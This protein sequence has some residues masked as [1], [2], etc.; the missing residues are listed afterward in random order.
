MLGS[1]RRLLDLPSC[2]CQAK[3]AASKRDVPLRAVPEEGA[4]L[5]LSG[6]GPGHGC[7][8]GRHPELLAPCCGGGFA[9]L[10]GDLALSCVAFGRRPLQN[11]PELRTGTMCSS[12]KVM[13]F[14]T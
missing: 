8:E 12:G 7:V 4:F 13:R 11:S 9:R 1:R 3:A 6:T 10:R 14:Q 2:V 5:L